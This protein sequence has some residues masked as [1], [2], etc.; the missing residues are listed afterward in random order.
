MAKDK[1]YPTP[2]E[3]CQLSISRRLFI[4][5]PA[6]RWKLLRSTSK[7]VFYSRGVEEMKNKI[8]LLFVLLS[9]LVCLGAGAAIQIIDF[10]YTLPDISGQDPEARNN[11]PN[12]VKA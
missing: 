9:L 1:F 10:T 5:T 11:D 12:G 4:S 2:Q 3:Y 8:V 6:C 7:L